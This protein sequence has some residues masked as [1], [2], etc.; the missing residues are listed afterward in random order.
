MVSKRWSKD[1]YKKFDILKP[2]NSGDFQ[3]V[4]DKQL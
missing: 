2:I 3:T 1:D 4:Q